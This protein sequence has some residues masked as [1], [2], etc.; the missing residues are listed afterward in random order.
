MNPMAFARDATMEIIIRDWWK[1]HFS[2]RR[3]S[4]IIDRICVGNEEKKVT[5]KF[6]KINII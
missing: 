2:Y 5:L 3:A 1:T 4:T 6:N